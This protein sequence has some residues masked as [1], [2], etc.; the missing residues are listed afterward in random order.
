MT[1]S[2]PVVVGTPPSTRGRGEESDLARLSN[3][4]LTRSL[5]LTSLMSSQWLMRPSI[6]ALGFMANAKS[7]L[8][9]PDR[10]PI[11]NKLLRWTVYDHFCA[12]VSRQEV[13]RTV[14]EYK[15]LG[16][17][18]IILTHAKE[19]LLEH[20]DG[21]AAGTK[22]GVYGEAHYRLVE[23]WKNN[24]LDTLRMLNQGDF[25]AL[26]LTGAGPIAVD[27]LKTGKAMPEAVM[28]ALDEI[29]AETKQKG[30]RLWFD[31]EQQGLQPTIDEWALEVMRKWNRDGQAV[32][33]NTIQA[34]LKAS[35]ANAER[36]VLLAARQG[37]T[38]GIKLVRGAYIENEVRALIHDTKADTDACYDAIADMLVSQRLPAEAEAE[39]L[40]F[41]SA[42]LMLATHNAEST[43]KARA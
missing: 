7:A 26:K 21:H 29:C 14:A 36:H 32:V 25:L 3:K 6:A 5:I 37:W 42:A 1:T 34:Y 16:F 17:Q 27:A 20:A 28:K 35:L 2:A 24:S 30:A 22:E 11:L 31:A 43:A 4:N 23:A 12:G 13:R 9:H 41:P 39:G 19:I 18:G 15:R 40:R 33:Y 8:F 10:N 38:V